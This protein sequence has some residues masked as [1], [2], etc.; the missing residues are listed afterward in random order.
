MINTNF[1]EEILELPGNS[2]YSELEFFTNNADQAFSL[3]Q[4]MAWMTGELAFALQSCSRV[5]IYEA[6]GIYHGTLN[7]ESTSDDLIDATQ[8]LPYPLFPS[9]PSSLGSNSPTAEMPISI[10]LTEF[11]F[12]L[13]Y[14]D[15]I[16]SVCNLDEKLTYEEPLPLVSVIYCDE[17]CLLILSL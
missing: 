3:P 11:H 8:L 9:S 17:I 16:A 14:K 15:R 6:P 12:I 1:C 13:L 7:F 4:G 5:T 10:A 2:Q